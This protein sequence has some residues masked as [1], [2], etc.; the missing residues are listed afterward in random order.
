MYDLVLTGGGGHCLS[1]LDTIYRINRYTDIAITDPDIE[2]GTEVL[3]S[4]VV[5]GDSA[6]AD[7]FNSGCRKAFIT[8]G[9]IKDT[10][11]RRKLYSLLKET[12]F[13]LIT[14]VDPS[15]V[16]SD[17]ALIE[18]GAFVGKN[19]VVNAAAVIGTSAIVNTGAVIEHECHVG[20]FSHI[21]CG[22]ILC[23]NVTVGHDCLIGAGATVIEGITIGNNAVV[24]A[25]SIVLRDVKESETVYGIVK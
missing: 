24:G 10:G 22:S 2:V 15:A 6:L 23:G 1:V 13:E 18:E 8:V 17:S 9:S 4:R 14:V 3:N 19:A 16:V 11:V 5:G 21:A 25:G 7:I 12:G 20:E